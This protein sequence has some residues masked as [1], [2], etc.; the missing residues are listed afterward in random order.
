VEGLLTEKNLKNVDVI[1]L[2]DMEKDYLREADYREIIRWLDGKNHSL[3]VLGGYNSFGPDGFRA[4]PVA[5]VLPV[6]FRSGPP[7]QTEA[8]FN[9]KLTNEGK[10]HPIFTLSN[11][12]VKDAEAWS[13]APRLEGMC[14]V[15]GLKPGA[16]ALAENPQVEIDN[17]P[18]VVLAVQRVGKGGQVMVL[19]A[20]TTWRWSRYLRILGRP[21][22]LYSRFWSQTIR[23]LAGRG[24]DE[25]RPPLVVS[26]DRPDYDVGKKVTVT[27]LRQAGGEAK[28]KGQVTVEITKPSGEALPP[29]PLKADAG[30]ADLMRGEFYP[31]AGGR[32]EVTATLTADNKPLANQ[33]AEFLVQGSDLELANTATNPG[34]LKAL[35]DATGGVYLDVDRAE[36]LADKIERKE[37]RSVRVKRTEYW[38][39]PW[40]FTAFLL[41]VTGE[42]FI[43]RRNH[44][45]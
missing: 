18:A 25:Q 26:T 38:N 4:T 16:V 17:K 30:N 42:W 21:D 6:V 36:E 40:L 3:L 13:N 44:L 20:D 8:A 32:Y 22:T 41:A 31:S 45:V 34:N 9:F 10:R 27:V 12:P 11:D 15:Q 7:Y 23:W 29:L 28:A 19:S 5:D 33:Q 24:A 1:V 39:S 35:A 37:R 43:R 14:L 2:G